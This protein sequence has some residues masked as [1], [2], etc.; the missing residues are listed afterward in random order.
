MLIRVFPPVHPIT[1]NAVGMAV[2]AVVLLAVAVASNEPLTLPRQVETWLALG[3]LTVVG[4]IVVF[5]LYL[6]VLAYWPASRAVYIDV[7]IPPVAVAL[8]A[9]LDHEPI[10]LGLIGGG[11]L[12]LAGVYIGALRP[13]STS[14]DQVHVPSERLGKPATAC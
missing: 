8:S 2:G 12:I 7:L 11:M 9:W 14:P 3:Y 1:M 5:V 10:T 6:V 4:S 13:G